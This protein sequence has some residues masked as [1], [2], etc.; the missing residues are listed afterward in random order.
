MPLVSLSRGCPGD[1]LQSR[2][3]VR[4]LRVR[5]PGST[6]APQWELARP[7]SQ[8]KTDCFTHHKREARRTS[9]M[10]GSFQSESPANSLDKTFGPKP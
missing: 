4:G 2:A 8:R 1:G 9:R 10:S 7:P 3:L 6:A 5:E